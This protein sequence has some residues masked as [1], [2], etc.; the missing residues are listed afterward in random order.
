MILQATTSSAFLTINILS[1][2]KLRLTAFFI[3]YLQCNHNGF[4]LPMLNLRMVV[5][6][7][8]ILKKT[9]QPFKSTGSHYHPV[10]VSLP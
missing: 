7:S 8:V 3:F 2:F 5:F 1:I 9:L 4:C 6:F 10:T